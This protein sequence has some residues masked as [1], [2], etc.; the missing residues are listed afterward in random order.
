MAG[1]PTSHFFCLLACCACNRG[2]GFFPGRAGARRS[3]TFRTV[4]AIACAAREKSALRLLR[5][6]RRAGKKSAS[7]GLISAAKKYQDIF[8]ACCAARWRRWI[9]FARPP[10]K[11]RSEQYLIQVN[12][13]RIKF[14]S[15]LN[16]ICVIPGRVAHC[17]GRVGFLRAART[18]LSSRGSTAGSGGRIGFRSEVRPAGLS[19]ILDGDRLTGRGFLRT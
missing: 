16:L 10:S 1:P 3:R 7:V 18:N 4:R 12:D 15:D 17:G 11:F 2:G 9:F 13:P 14:C 6:R 19:E 5:S 8:D